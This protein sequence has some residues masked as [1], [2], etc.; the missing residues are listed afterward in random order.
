MSDLPRGDR[1]LALARDLLL[2]DLLPLLPKD[3]QLDGR[4]IANAMAIAGRELE[5]AAEEER[6][7]FAQV[8]PELAAQVKSGEAQRGLAAEI[9]S[10]RHDGDLPIHELLLRVARARLAIANPKALRMDDDA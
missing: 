10:G 4:M 9:R 1:L 8:Q 3:K 5:R 6:P 2:R 7:A